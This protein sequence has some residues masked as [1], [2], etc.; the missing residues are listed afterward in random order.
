MLHCTYFVKTMIDKS[1][2]V[3][4]EVASFV[5]GNPVDNHDN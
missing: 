5:M 3:V 1:S 4:V 2:A